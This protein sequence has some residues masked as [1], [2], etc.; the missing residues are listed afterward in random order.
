MK[1][2]DIERSYHQGHRGDPM[3]NV[4]HHLWV[5]DPIRKYRDDGHEFSG[6]GPF[7]EWLEAQWDDDSYDEMNAADEMARE[8]CWEQA[9][10]EARKIWP[11]YSTEMV[12]EKKFFPEYPPGCQMRFTGEKVPRKKYR[13][14]VYSAGRSG[15]WLAVTGLGDVDEWDLMDLNAWR[16][17]NKYVRQI[18]DEEYPY[19][20][21]WHLY[22]NVYEPTVVEPARR[23]ADSG[24]R[25]DA[26]ML[27]AIVSSTREEAA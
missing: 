18:A 8:S 19:E 1:K 7:W 22:V 24:A 4:K 10:E 21:I 9:I 6:D 11:A 27:D 25:A 16:K 3:I 2:S 23:S 26:E 13:A 15:G 17:F 14:Q 5:P 20:F 12:D